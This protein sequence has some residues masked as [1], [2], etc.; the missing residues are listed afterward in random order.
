MCPDS[1]EEVLALV[2]AVELGAVAALLEA[3]EGSDLALLVEP[4]AK[5]LTKGAHLSQEMAEW[6]VETWALAVCQTPASVNLD[7]A[8]APPTEVGEL[9]AEAA[10]TSPGVAFADWSLIAVGCALGG[11]LPVAQSAVFTSKIPYSVPHGLSGA[12]GGTIGGGLG[13]WFGRVDRAHSL[14]VERWQRLTAAALGAMA[15]T[16]LGSVAGSL[17]A[18]PT[19]LWASALLG[20]WVGAQLGRRHNWSAV[21]GLFTASWAVSAFAFF[22]PMF[23]ALSGNCTFFVVLAV[24]IGL[25]VLLGSILTT[26]R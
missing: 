23:K 7:E 5:Q 21:V 19:L 11:W 14:G 15:G 24:L 26:S 10:P 22:S 2:Q 1:P 13:W 16:A 25:V 3:P 20:G 12:L 8:P 9:P 17:L 4:L 18:Q 6:T